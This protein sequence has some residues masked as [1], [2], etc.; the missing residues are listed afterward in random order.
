MQMNLNL[1]LLGRSGIGKTSFSDSFCNRKYET[2]NP[3]RER[4]EAIQISSLK[5]K[6]EDIEISIID[7]P[8]YEQLRIQEYLESVER[9]LVEKLEKHIIATKDKKNSNSRF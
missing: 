3:I 8:G 6:K 1:L 9:F 4:T 7:I 5:D 2:I